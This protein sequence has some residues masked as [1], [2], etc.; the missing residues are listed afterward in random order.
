MDRALAEVGG[1]RRQAGQRLGIGLRTLDE[2]VKRYG[3]SYV[4]VT[5]LARRAL[6]LTGHPG[7]GKTT[8]VR[9]IVAG[10]GAWRARGF[11]TEEIRVG[12]RRTGFRL[13]TLDGRIETLAHV[14]LASRHRIGAYAVDVAMLDRVAVS[15]L[16]ADPAVQVH[17]VDEIGKMECLSTRFVAAVRDLLDSRRLLIATI[18]ARG[19]GFIDETRKRPDVEVWTVTRQNRE[20]LPAMALDWLHERVEA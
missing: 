4:P 10:L 8:V 5:G 20:A 19:G 17:L 3:L 18:G 9:R 12:G 16:G 11:T 7:V 1:N 2:K 14:D 15:T 13:E 6:L